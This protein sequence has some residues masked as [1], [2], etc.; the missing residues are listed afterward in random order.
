MSVNVAALKALQAHDKEVGDERSGVV[1]DAILNLH[2]RL[3]AH[4][5]GGGMPGSTVKPA[6]PVIPL[7]STPAASPFKTP[8]AGP[9]AG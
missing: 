7:P 5:S 4:E 9:Q 1:I 8:P 6:A 3:M 2:E